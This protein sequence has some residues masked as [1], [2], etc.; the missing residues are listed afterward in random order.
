M[1]MYISLDYYTRFAPHGAGVNPRVTAKSSGNRFKLGTQEFRA[2]TVSSIKNRNL[3][4]ARLGLAYKTI[5][6]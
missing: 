1:G 6:G 4:A 2:I 5:V 3:Y